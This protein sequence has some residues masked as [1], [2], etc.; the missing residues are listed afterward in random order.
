MHPGLPSWFRHPSLQ[1]AGIIPQKRNAVSF[2]TSAAG[3]DP[4]L[5]DQPIDCL[6]Q[7][8]ASSSHVC[9]IVN[10]SATHCPQNGGKPASLLLA[11][12]VPE[13]TA[14]ATATAEATVT[15]AHKASLKAPPVPWFRHPTA[16]ACARGY[17]N[18]W[19]GGLD[20]SMAAPNTFDLIWGWIG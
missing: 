13:A 17:F 16:G 5:G 2:Y 15:A 14:A 20:K 18:K 7:R 6:P 19:R 10:D 3:D 11:G 4:A 1:D 8:L 9:V 12:G